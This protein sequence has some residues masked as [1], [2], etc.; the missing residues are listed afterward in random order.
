MRSAWK[1]IGEE[2]NK[3]KPPPSSEYRRH[4]RSTRTRWEPMNVK[5]TGRIDSNREM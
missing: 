5:R 4:R 1:E 2:K 3:S